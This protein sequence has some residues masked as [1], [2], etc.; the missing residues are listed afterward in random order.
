MAFNL[1]SFSL[2]TPSQFNGGINTWNYFSSSDAAATIDTSGYF[3]AVADRVAVG[4]IIKVKDSAGVVKQVLVASNSSGVVDV[5]DGTAI[6][7]TNTD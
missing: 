7:A 5:T 2:E 3:N 4:D 6:S 1:Q